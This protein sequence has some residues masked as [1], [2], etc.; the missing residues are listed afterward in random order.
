MNSA[1]VDFQDYNSS[2]LRLLTLPN[3]FLNL[4]LARGELSDPGNDDESYIEK[5]VDLRS[6]TADNRFNFYSGDWSHLS[7]WEP[8]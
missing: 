5:E 4:H 2:V 3:L 8:Y 7:V 6:L 1:R